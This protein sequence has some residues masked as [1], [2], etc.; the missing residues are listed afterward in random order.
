MDWWDASPFT[1]AQ[2][3]FH[4]MTAIRIR[5]GEKYP[6]DAGALD[7]QLNW[8]DR[9]DSGEPVRSYRFNY[10]LLPSTPA[11]DGV[12]AKTRERSH[13]RVGACPGG[14]ATGASAQRAKSRWSNWPRRT[15]RRLSG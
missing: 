8:N 1:V 15:S 10:Q 7:Y 3:P 4:G 9:F 6:D 5:R 13:E 2:L 14:E 11:E 12:P